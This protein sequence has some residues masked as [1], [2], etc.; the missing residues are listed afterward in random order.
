MTRLIAK[1]IRDL[2]KKRGLTQQ[3]LAVIYKKSQAT[4]ARIESLED[5][6]FSI[7][8]LSEI[9]YILGADLHINI[10]ERENE[11]N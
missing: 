11:R 1:Q 8:L 10:R 2:R 4:I 6:Q 5:N 3:Q 9:A 7:K